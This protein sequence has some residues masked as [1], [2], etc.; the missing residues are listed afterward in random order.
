MSYSD[1]PVLFATT[2]ALL[3]KNNKQLTKASREALHKYMSHDEVMQGQ[4]AINPVL[5]SVVYGEMNKIMAALGSG[6]VATTATSTTTKS[7]VV[8][9]KPAPV[10]KEPEPDADDDCGIFDLFG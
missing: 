8:A 1:E 2:E 3:K 7:N 4:F 10:Q 5:W 6:A 9:P